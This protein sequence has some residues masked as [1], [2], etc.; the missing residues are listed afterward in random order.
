MGGKSE[1]SALKVNSMQLLYMQ[2]PISFFMLLG[3]LPF[4]EPD[5]MDIFKFEWFSAKCILAVVGSGI[6]AALV[7]I[8]IFLVISETNPVSYN[9]LGHVKLCT[10][11]S[12]G[13]FLFGDPFEL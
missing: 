6:L 11:L 2:A 7:N 5:F 1:Q 9:V 8:S 13:Y 3:L 4:S 12:S 10:I